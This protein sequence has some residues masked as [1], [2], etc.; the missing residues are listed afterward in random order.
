VRFHLGNG[1]EVWAEAVQHLL[2]EHLLCKHKA[3]SSNPS[4]SKKKIQY[5]QNLTITNLKNK[6][7]SG[8]KKKQRREEERKELGGREEEREGKRKERRNEKSNLLVTIVYGQ[9]AF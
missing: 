6:I 9:Y 2:C 1:L 7:R 4:P 8:R 3:L 5:C